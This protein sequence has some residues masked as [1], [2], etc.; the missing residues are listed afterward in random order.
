[1]GRA[2]RY[3]LIQSQVLMWALVGVVTYFVAR[4][5]SLVLA[6]VYLVPLVALSILVVLRI[7]RDA[8]R[9]EE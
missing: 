6:L 9:R 3:A 1:M 7:R 8:G 2:E 4:K 5:V